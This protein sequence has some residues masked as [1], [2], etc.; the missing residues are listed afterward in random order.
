MKPFIVKLEPFVAAM[1]TELPSLQDLVGGS[2]D[3][4]QEQKHDKMK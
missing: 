4:E 1:A 2:A 3:M